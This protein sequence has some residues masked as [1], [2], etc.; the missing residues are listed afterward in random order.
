MIEI[1]VKLYAT[2]RRYRPELKVGE[3]LSIQVPEGTSVGQVIAAVGIPPET[4]RKVFSRGRSVEEDHVLV[5]GDDVALFPPVAGG[6]S[7]GR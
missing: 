2:L 7:L 6:E 3:A 5:N 1:Q 4:V